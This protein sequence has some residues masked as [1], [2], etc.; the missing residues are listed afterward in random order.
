MKGDWRFGAGECSGES[1]PWRDSLAGCGGGRV[2]GIQLDLPTESM[3]EGREGSQQPLQ[4]WTWVCRR[5]A[6]RSLPGVILEPDC[7]KAGC[8]L[9]WGEPQ[10]RKACWGRRDNWGTSS[11]Q[12]PHEGR[13]ARQTA[14]FRKQRPMFLWAQEER[15]KSVATGLLDPSALC[16][17]SLSQFVKQIICYGAAEERECW[18]SRYTLHRCNRQDFGYGGSQGIAKVFINRTY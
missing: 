14:E 4:P 9:T 12:S 10:S 5:R 18:I 17:S 6:S 16:F 7:E 2:Q 3:S 11:T 8:L 1:S 13:P 15:W